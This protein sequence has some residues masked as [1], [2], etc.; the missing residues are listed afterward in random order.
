MNYTAGPA[1]FIVTSGCI[2]YALGLIFKIS[3]V[4]P[5]QS[6]RPLLGVLTSAMRERSPL[7]FTNLLRSVA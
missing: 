1:V 5:D 3:R 6:T 7:R 4:I 2:L